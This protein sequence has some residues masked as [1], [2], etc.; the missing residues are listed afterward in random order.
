MASKTFEL[1]ALG[2]I[3]VYKRRANR[4]INLS[5]SSQGKVRVS[6]P[7]WMPYQSGINFA[8][9]KERWI[10]EKRPKPAQFSANQRVGYSKQ[11]YFNPDP[12]ISKPK[13]KI[14][15]DQIIVSHPL[16]LNVDHPTVQ[17]TAQNGALKALRIQAE[18]QLPSRI[19]ALSSRYNLPY[20]SLK[21]KRLSRRWGSCDREGHIVLNLYLVQ[22]PSEL[23]D[24][25]IC[26]ELTHTAHLNHSPDFWSAL[27]D[28]SP[29][30]KRLKIALRSFSPGVILSP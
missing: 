24:Y 20:D 6:I 22:L 19:E 10:V 11:M 3:T 4:R 1:D 25:V 15:G 17:L 21:I 9:S 13:F 16:N 7:T 14:S 5:I 29:N 30:T 27:E 23:I 2:I 18:A 26:H 28:I 8:R 12:S